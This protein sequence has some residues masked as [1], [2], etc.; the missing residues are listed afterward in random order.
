[1]IKV[2]FVCLGNICRSPMAEFVFK[3]MVFEEGLEDKII[4]SSAATSSYEIGNPVHYGTQSIL[5]KYNIS[6]NGKYAKKLNTDDLNADYLIGMDNNNIYNIKRV[7]K[8]NKP[9]VKKLLEFSGDDRDIE[10]PYYTLDF[11][12]TYDD[13]KKGCEGLLKYLKNNHNFY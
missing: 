10:D 2:V 3:K 6:C 12:K 11:Q 1:M 7:L 8:N 13:V 5:K 4:I 9:I